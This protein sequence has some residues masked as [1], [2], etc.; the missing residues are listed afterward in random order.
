MNHANI[1]SQSLADSD[2]PEAAVGIITCSRPEEA[3]LLIKRNENEHDPWSGH[4]A[5]PGGRKENWDA[6]IYETCVREVQ[7]ETGIIL[8]P[9]TLQQ[10][11]APA[12]AGRNV[13]APILVQP[14]VFR[15]S[16]RPEVTIEEKEIARHVWLG[17]SLFKDL[18]NHR[19]VETMPA[20]FRPVFPMDD[21]YI[22]GFT[23]GLLCRLLGVDQQRL[24]Q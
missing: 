5:F 19:L 8:E 17:V 15:L 12:R 7:E 16:E 10:T 3:I 14:Y 22:W 24:S 11:C 20:M 9:E 18:A 4:Y 2:A 1:Q 6:T 21:Y 13:Q 23:Y